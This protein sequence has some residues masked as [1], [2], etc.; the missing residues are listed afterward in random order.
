[1]S[2]H[3]LF[4]RIPDNERQQKIFIRRAP[5]TENEIEQIIEYSRDDPRVRDF[6][7]NATRFGSREAYDRFLTPETVTYPITD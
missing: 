4:P 3:E 5:L 1:M 2:S 6:T 7:S